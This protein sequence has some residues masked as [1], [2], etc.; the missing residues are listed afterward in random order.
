M[1]NTTLLSIVS[2]KSVIAKMEAKFLR[3]CLYVVQ[4][5]RSL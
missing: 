2:S 5:V 3:R 4:I 1:G